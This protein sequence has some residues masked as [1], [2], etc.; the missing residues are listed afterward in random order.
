MPFSKIAKKIGIGTDT[1]IRRYKALKKDGVIIGS[2]IWLNL[3][4]CGIKGEVDFFIK[5]NAEVDVDVIC[6][7][8]AS[9]KNVFW[10]S[11]TLGEYQILA[12]AAYEDIDDLDRITIELSSLKEIKSYEFCLSTNVTPMRVKMWSKA[13]DPSLASTETQTNPK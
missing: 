1:V 3:P 8:I 13:Y 4:L 11:I 9:I 5:T 6:K 10:V 2:G 12:L 7:K